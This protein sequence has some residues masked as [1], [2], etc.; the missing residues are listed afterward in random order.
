ME[1]I[2]KYLIKSCPSFTSI[3]ILSYLQ[4]KHTHKKLERNEE[5]PKQ[6][7]NTFD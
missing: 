5:N 7:S 4:K 3:P 6:R 1:L 2:K